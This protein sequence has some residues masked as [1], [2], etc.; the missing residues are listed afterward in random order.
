MKNHIVLFALVLI[1]LVS[2]CGGNPSDQE[3]TEEGFLKIQDALK[4]KFGNKAFY[5]ELNISYYEAI[6]MV[7]GVTV[8]N[9]PESLEMGQWSLSQNSWTQ[10]S[11]ISLEVPEGMQASDYMFQLG[12]PIDLGLL[13]RLI[14][15]SKDN[16][17]SEKDIPKPAFQLAWVKIPKDGVRSKIEY[18]VKLQ[19]E[20]GGT[21]FTYNY[22]LNGELI[23]LFY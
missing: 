4:E 21:T 19:P 18:L 22:N 17:E 10:T 1:V 13:G 23:D 11:E 5:T 6:G 3:A 14:E 2:G 7:I 15:E 8:T 20:N 12:D 9:E 16:L